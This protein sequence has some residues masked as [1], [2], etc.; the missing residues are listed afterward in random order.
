MLFGQ[1]REDDAAVELVRIAY[2]MCGRNGLRAAN[3][4][5]IA[6]VGVLGMLGLRA[7]LDI[8]WS[9]KDECN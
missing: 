6:A 8:H 5:V 2:L 9:V 4:L 3:A 1:P 7:G